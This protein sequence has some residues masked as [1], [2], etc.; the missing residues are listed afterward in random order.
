MPYAG[1]KDKILFHLKYAHSQDGLRKN[2]EQKQQQQKHL[3]DRR[4]AFAVSETILLLL[5]YFIF[6]IFCV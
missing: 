2:E 1:I 5:L 3:I 4:V 6:S